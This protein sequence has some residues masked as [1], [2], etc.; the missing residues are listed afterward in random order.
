MTLKIAADQSHIGASFMEIRDLI[1]YFFYMIMLGVFTLGVYTQNAFHLN[2]AIANSF[3][4]QP[5]YCEDERTN[6]FN[7]SSIDELWCYLNQRFMVTLNNHPFWG[8]IGTQ[9]ETFLLRPPRI[10]QVRVVEEECL[11]PVGNLKCYGEFSTSTEEKG[12]FK[13]SNDSSWVYNP[14]EEMGDIWFK[15]LVSYYNSAG[16]YY[17]LNDESQLAFY[18]ENDWIDRQTRA[19]FID[20]TLYNVNI[21]LFS[22]CQIMFELPPTG[23][24]IPSYLFSTVKLIRYNNRFDHGVMACEIVFLGLCIYYTIELILEIFY[25]KLSFFKTVNNWIDVFILALSWASIFLL[26][27]RHEAS[28]SII[29][30]ENTKK[31]QELPDYQELKYIHL[32][33]DRVT[34]VTLF[35]TSLKFYR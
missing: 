5:Y 32:T 22:V 16:Y 30:D 21:N 8:A 3:I 9:N 14:P 31:I 24:I 34:A 25:F 13:F 29:W 26:R 17:T 15:G 20:F 10:R 7:V 23:G 4:H 2:N 28:L 35:C 6:I 1:I 11:I 12:P 19:I 33:V 18:E 27:F